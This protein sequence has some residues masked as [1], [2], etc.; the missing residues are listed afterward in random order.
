MKLRR[1]MMF[2]PGNNP[3]MIKDAQ[4][5]GADS[6]MFDL[7][8][9]V[10]INEKDAARY[11]VHQALKTMDFS[12]DE[13]VVRVN[14]LDTPFGRHD[15]EAVVTAGVNVIRLPK[16][17]TPQDILDMEA[18]IT[19]VEEKHNIPVGRTKMMAAVESALGIRYAYEIAE[20]SN[21]L[22]GIALGAEDFVTSMKTKRSPEGI[23]LLAARSQ[24]LLAARAAG[25]YALDTVFSNVNDEEGFRNE[26]ELIKQLGFDGKSIINPRQID[27]V[28]EVFAPTAKEIE[29]SIRVI[30]AAKEAESK[31]SGVI[32][33]DG[34]MV[35]KPIIERAQRVLA[36][37][38]A[39]G[40]S[41]EGS[42][43]NAN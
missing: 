39:T 16:T 29:H 37:A 10:S 7:E 5:Y 15:V 17:E 13:V 20:A 26:V 31:G 8:D 43:L 34:R 25:I 32:S 22:I 21:R 30:A 28:N 27:I 9:A 14:G 18:L 3:A 1:T 19:E 41:I 42:E 11:L 40:I 6:I 35:D 36:L 12:K 2:V 38:E 23:E 24:I 4:I 33:L